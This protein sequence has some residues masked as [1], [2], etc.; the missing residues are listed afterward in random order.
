[1][2]LF[3]DLWIMTAQGWGPS[4]PIHSHPPPLH[5]QYLGVALLKLSMHHIVKKLL[6]YT[7]SAS[8]YTKLELNPLNYTAVAT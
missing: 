2:G 5:L 8:T 3:F 7:K 4:F 6:F 1:M